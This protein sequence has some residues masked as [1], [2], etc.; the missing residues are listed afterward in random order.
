MEKLNNVNCTDKKL[1]RIVYKVMTVDDD[2]MFKKMMTSKRQCF[3]AQ[4]IRLWPTGK[5]R[6]RVMKCDMMERVMTAISID[7][8]HRS[9]RVKYTTRNGHRYS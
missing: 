7:V 2:L 1:H 9:S 6:V 4:T 3:T 5:R 8:K